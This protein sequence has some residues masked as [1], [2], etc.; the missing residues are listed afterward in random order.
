M[1]QTPHQ[2][3]YPKKRKYDPTLRFGWF[4]KEYELGKEMEDWYLSKWYNYHM[5]KELNKKSVLGKEN[6]N[7]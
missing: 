3:W 7:K 5:I 6:P 2:I 4:P 1:K